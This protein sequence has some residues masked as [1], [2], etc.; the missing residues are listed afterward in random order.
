MATKR[1]EEALLNPGTGGGNTAG[2]ACT[3]CGSDCGPAATDG[4]C[5]KCF[6]VYTAALELIRSMEGPGDPDEGSMVSF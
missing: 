3:G 5:P 6:K 4:K 2:G 1:K